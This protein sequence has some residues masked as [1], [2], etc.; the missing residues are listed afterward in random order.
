[1]LKGNKGEWSELY[2]VIKMLADGKLLQ[3]K[4]DLSADENLSYIIK[5][6]YKDEKNFILEFTL[7]D[8]GKIITNNNLD[9]TLLTNSIDDFKILASKMLLC[10]QKSSKVFE[11]ESVKVELKRLRISKLKADT[12]SK[13][14]VRARIYDFRIAKEAELGFSIKSLL[15]AKTTLLNTGAGNNF[16]YR[17]EDYKEQDIN[18]FNKETF[19]NTSRTNIVGRR[20]ALI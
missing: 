12:N 3:A 8:D 15:G 5:K 6:V 7:T 13:I 4:S 9:E 16:R 17:I 2:V 14:D 10:I 20:I 18:Q 1:M 19:L 11:I